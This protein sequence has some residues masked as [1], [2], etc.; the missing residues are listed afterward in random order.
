MDAELVVQGGTVID[1]TGESLCQAEAA[2]TGGRVVAVGDGLTGADAIEA[3]GRVI[4]PGSW[5]SI[6]TTTP[7]SF[8]IRHSRRRAGTV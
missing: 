6:R 1:G 8:G 7:R 5:T 3:R 2:F 4:G